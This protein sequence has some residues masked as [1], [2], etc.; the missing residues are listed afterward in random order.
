LSIRL[1]NGQYAAALVL[2]ADHSNVEYGVNLIG[3]LDYLS[4]EKPTIGS[5]SFVRTI[6]TTVRWTWLGINP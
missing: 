6:I 2:A 5:G 1:S 4:L 3:V